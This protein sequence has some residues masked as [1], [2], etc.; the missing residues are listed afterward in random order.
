MDGTRDADAAWIRE[1]LQPGCDVDPVAINL[2]AFDHHVARIDANPEFHSAP[3]WETRILCP[4]AVRNFDG[5]VHCFHNTR[6][7]SQNT[8]TRRV[9]KTS[10]MTLNV[11]VD[12]FA[13][14]R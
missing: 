14:T 9:N 11:A 1:T 6:E 4:K 13:I 5:A 7:F 3:R 8:I 2:L 10:A 12:D